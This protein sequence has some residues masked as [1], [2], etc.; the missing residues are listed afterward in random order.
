MDLFVTLYKKKKK[1]DISPSC[2]SILSERHVGVQG[3]SVEAC[4]TSSNQMERFPLS[5]R[6]DA[7]RER[8]M[9]GG[10]VQSERTP[11]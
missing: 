6:S 5:H 3:T 8:E 1:K 10:A 4:Q 9:H 2:Q 11:K 7:S